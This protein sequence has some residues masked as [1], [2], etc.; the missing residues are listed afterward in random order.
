MSAQKVNTLRENVII[1]ICI[2]SKNL[3]LIE[4]TINNYNILGYEHMGMCNE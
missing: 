3:P 2:V 1:S 4:V